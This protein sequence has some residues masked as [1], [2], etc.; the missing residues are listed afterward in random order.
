MGTKI[1][2]STVHGIRDAYRKELSQR[3]VANQ[4]VSTLATLPVKK[5]GRPVILGEFIDSVIEKLRYH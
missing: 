5:R 2:G 4:E 3:C 1:T